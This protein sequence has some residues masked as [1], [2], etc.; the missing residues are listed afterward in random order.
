MTEQGQGLG[1]GLTT[2][3]FGNG[4]PIGKNC[5]MNGISVVIDI[6]WNFLHVGRTVRCILT[7]TSTSLALA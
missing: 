1:L 6:G 5:Q 7:S 2:I 3:S 4:I